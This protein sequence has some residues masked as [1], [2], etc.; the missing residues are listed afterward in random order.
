MPCFNQ[1]LILITD[2]N[3]A[4]II[5]YPTAFMSVKTQL[6]YFI[7]DYYLRQYSF[8]HQNDSYEIDMN[9][10]GAKKINNIK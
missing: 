7:K 3:V 1:E 2:N 6:Q 9:S 5:G 10:Y 8:F 4:P